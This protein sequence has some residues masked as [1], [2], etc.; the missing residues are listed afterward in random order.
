MFEMS[1]ELHYRKNVIR[2]CPTRQKYC[3]NYA[4]RSF[5]NDSNAFLYYKSYVRCF[6]FMFFVTTKTYNIMIP[7]IDTT[8]MLLR[9]ENHKITIENDISLQHLCIKKTLT[10]INIQ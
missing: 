7:K 10:L 5:L 2:K 4:K 8:K 3:I 1:H 6:S 9:F